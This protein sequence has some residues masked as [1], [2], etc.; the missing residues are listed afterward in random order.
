[1]LRISS[2]VAEQLDLTGVKPKRATKSQIYA[3]KLSDQ[4]RAFGL[5]RFESEFYFVPGKKYRADWYFP[6]YRLLVEMEGIT[7]TLVYVK[8]KGGKLLKRMVCLGG[9]TEVEGY[10]K[11]LDKYNSATELGYGLV[12]VVPKWVD[13]PHMTALNWVIRA[14]TTRGY[15][16]SGS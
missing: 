16:V 12:R 10:F 7:P 3:Q 14:L 15:Q 4:F 5:P 8:G 2:T 11:D 13:D 1:M 6:D 9:H